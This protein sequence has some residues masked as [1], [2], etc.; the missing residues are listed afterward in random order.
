M[1]GFNGMIEED[2][3]ALVDRAV[4]ATSV[5]STVTSIVDAT[6]TTDICDDETDAPEST[7]MPVANVTSAIAVVTTAR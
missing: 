5:S 6:S 1:D 7:L 4:M 3:V 2:D